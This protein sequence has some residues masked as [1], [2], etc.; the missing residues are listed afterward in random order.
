MMPATTLTTLSSLVTERAAQTPNAL[1]ISDVK[2]RLTYGALDKVANQLARALSQLGVQPGDRVGLWLD[3]SVKGVVA[4]QAILR[5][6]A[7]YVPLDP[8]S[9]LTRIAKILASCQ[10]KVLVTQAAYTQQL[11][12][13]QLRQGHWNDVDC[14]IVDTSAGQLNW[15]MLSQFSN[16][17]LPPSDVQET[18]LAYILYT[19]G[20]TGQPKGVCI[21]HRNA[22]AFIT[23]A[24]AT[25][26]AQAEDRF[27]NHA[28]FHFD[29][30]VLDLY[31]AFFS[32]ASVHLIPQELAYLPQHLVRFLIDHQIT[33]WYSVPSALILMM[34]QGDLLSVE[35][36]ALK[37]LIYAGEPFP[38]KDLR[39]LM[40]LAGVRFFN[41]Y[42]PT[43]TNV[44]TYFEVQA[45][46]REAVS[47]PIGKACS[48]NRVWALKPD[49]TEATADEE[50]E[51]I[52]DGPTVML[53]YWG[54]SPQGNQPY[55][56]G[57]IVRL[58]G[59]GN[60]VYIGRRDRL[61]KVRGHRIEAGEIE[62]AL[63]RH[64]DIKSAAVVVVGEGIRAR[65]VAFLVLHQSSQRLSVVQIKQ[66]CAQHLPRYMIVDGVRYL[67]VL[68][69]N[70]NGKVDRKFL[71]AQALQTNKKLNTDI[72][73]PKRLKDE[74]LNRSNNLSPNS[75]F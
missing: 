69:R 23:W 68:P 40:D 34:Q 17:P 15:D 55:G 35:G 10:I 4:M 65:L 39:S 3:K 24:A 47:V 67:E 22:L 59:D 54:H 58:R 61:L 44:C 11:Y 42:G 8:L 43:E 19:S 60:F 56:T 64:P 48:G 20:S 30:S 16:Q 14:F 32:G 72:S 71:V 26:G 2:Q 49:G 5:L 21:S 28:P 66:H 1:A 73:Q 70:R 36:L 33:V 38:I 74:N 6:G 51:L 53:G 27:S 37:T 9:P 25:I 18:D 41:F 29:L 45:L 75:R 13:E 57:D 7:A 62:A 12:A 63:L 31:V 50:G 52:V 46:E